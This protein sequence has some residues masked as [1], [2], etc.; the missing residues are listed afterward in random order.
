MEQMKESLKTARRISVTLDCWSGRNSIDN[1]MGITV[2]FLDT[3]TN[4]RKCFKIGK[5]CVFENILC[6]LNVFSLSSV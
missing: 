5:F 6:N 4:D 1:F 3:A 2:H